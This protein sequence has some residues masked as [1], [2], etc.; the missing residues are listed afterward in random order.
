MTDKLRLS[1]TQ[2]MMLARCGQQYE[3]RYIKGVRVP[4]GVQLTIGTGTHAGIEADLRSKMEWG[5]LL[6]AEEVAATTADAT[7]AEWDKQPPVRTDDDPDQGEAIDTAVGLARMYHAEIAPAVAPTGIEREFVLD[8][9]GCSF[10][11]VGFIDVEEDGRIRDTKTAAKAPSG[12]EAERSPQLSLYWLE[13]HLRGKDPE[14]VLDYLVKG[15]KPRAV[16][17][18][19]RRTPLDAQRMLVWIEAA[20]RQIE[21]GAFPPTDPSNWW[22]SAKWCGYYDR[23][24]FGARQAAVVPVTRL[25]ARVRAAE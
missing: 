18:R 3:W 21:A 24:A 10:D 6:S 25:T 2:L 12:D 15:K 1:K 22:C 19:A 16:T 23:C 17:L 9:D 7:R 13:A 5:Q 4:P 8:I 20:S 14:V 11:L